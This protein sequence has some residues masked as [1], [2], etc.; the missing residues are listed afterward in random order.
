VRSGL[1][2]WSLLRAV[3]VVVATLIGYWLTDSDLDPFW[4]AIVVLIVFQPDLQQTVFKAAQRGLGT[5]VGA[6]TAAALLAVTSSEPVIVAVALVGTFGAVA[7]YGANYMIYAFFLTNA[8]LLYYWFA[9][10]HNVSEATQRLAATVIGIAL[11][12]AGMGVLSVRERRSIAA[13]Q[14]T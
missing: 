7:F 9:A 3:L 2:M 12:F 13:T 10:D 4:T 6:M 8:V 5:L 1:G 14:T 11:A